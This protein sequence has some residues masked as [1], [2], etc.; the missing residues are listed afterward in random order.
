[1]TSAST[2]ND[3]IEECTQSFPT[4]WVEVPGCA[5]GWFVLENGA[6]IGMRS[7]VGSLVGAN[8]LISV[9]IGGVFGF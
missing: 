9:G 2:R 3:E 7:K 1:M 8:V 4:G 6:M 5:V